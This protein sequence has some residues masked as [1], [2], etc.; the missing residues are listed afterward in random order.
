MYG[1]VN[2]SLDISGS[3][4]TTS[5]TVV[6]NGN[7]TATTTSLTLDS[8][9]QIIT[10]SFI[11]TSSQLYLSAGSQIIASDTVVLQSSTLTIPV[12]SQNTD[13]LIIGHT[14]ESINNLTLLFNFTQYHISNNLIIPLLTFKNFTACSGV[15]VNSIITGLGDCTAA[16]STTV[17]S[18]EDNQS[19]VSVLF[20]VYNTCTSDHFL[21]YVIGGAVGGFAL[22]I[23]SLTLVLMC[24]PSLE[25]LRDIVFPFREHARQK[26][27]SKLINS[28]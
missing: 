12:T 3:N 26:K 17:T 10:E 2:G 16:T 6:V 9:S 22:I 4:V 20:N 13:P 11:V 28:E 14:C 21:D 7:L 23:C 27:L 1:A 24:S 5:G 15:H 18:N 25:G 19:T 8:N